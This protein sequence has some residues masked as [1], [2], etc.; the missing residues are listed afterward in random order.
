MGS[1]WWHFCLK[2]HNKMSTTR[3]KVSHDAFTKSKIKSQIFS[4]LGVIRNFEICHG[5][6]ML[7]LSYTGLANMQQYTLDAI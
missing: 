3:A 5:F 7:Q 6:E 1:L 2:W 4:T